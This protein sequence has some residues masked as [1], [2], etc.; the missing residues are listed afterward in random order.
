AACDYHAKTAIV[1]ARA[2]ITPADARARLA[3]AGGRVRAA[4]AEGPAR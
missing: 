1:A 4:L 3:H 2:G